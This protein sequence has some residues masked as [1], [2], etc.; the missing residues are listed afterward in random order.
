[1]R[2]F[3]TNLQYPSIRTVMREKID[4]FLPAMD[5]RVAEEIISQLRNSKTVQNITQLESGLMSS[6]ALM[7]VAENAKADYVLLLT[8][9]VKVVLG[10]GALDRMLRV[11][12]D[13]NAA[14]VYSDYISKKEVDGKVVNEKHPVI[15][16]S[17]AAS[18]TTSISAVCGCLRP[19][20]CIPSPCR[21]VST[22]ISM[23]DSMP[24]ACF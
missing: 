9:P 21:R 20:C 23:L 13:S 10:Q 12:S 15:D 11:A 6:N 16:Y 2:I 14:M 17:L 1:M 19:R 4:C 3:A 5:E 22:T 8:K 7:Q 24:C 18:A